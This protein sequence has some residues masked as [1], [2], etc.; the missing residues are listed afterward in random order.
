[1]PACE[2]Q[3]MHL[4]YLLNIF[5]LST[6]LF[7]NFSKSSLIPLNMDNALATRLAAVL[8]YKIGSTPF[9]YLGLPMGTTRPR[10]IDFMPM[11]ERV[12]RRLSCSSSMLNQGSRL[13]LLV[14]VLT[15]MPIHFLCSLNIPPGMCLWRGNNDTPK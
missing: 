4:K 12:E 5:S 7:V 9:T 14:S 11:V 2:E 13:Q 3:I 10:I 6:G 15:S 1:M 8:G